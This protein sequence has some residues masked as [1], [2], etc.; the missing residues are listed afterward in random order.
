[1]SEIK[2]NLNKLY[3]IFKTTK[4]PFYNKEPNL[5][6]TKGSK[7]IFLLRNYKPLK[8]EFLFKENTPSNNL[9]YTSRLYRSDKYNPMKK[10]KSGMIKINYLD[11]NHPDFQLIEKNK[12]KLKTYNN[13]NNNH[14]SD[15]YKVSPRILG[16]ELVEYNKINN[17]LLNILNDKDD[18]EYKIILQKILKKNK[19]AFLFSKY[20][21]AQT[22]TFHSMTQKNGFGQYPPVKNMLLKK[23][24]G[25]KNEK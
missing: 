8:K 20:K 22:N 12:E 14:K 5:K 19:T 13:M 1:M 17:N 23:Y 10:L 2:K 4:F 6:K 11:K 24:F 21:N 3:K 7:N 16:S 18:F 9:Y 25:I 15:L